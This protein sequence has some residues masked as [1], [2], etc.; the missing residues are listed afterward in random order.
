[1]PDIP[2]SIKAAAAALR[3]GQITSAQMTAAMLDRIE[4]LNPRVGAFIA[5]TGETAMAAAEQADA[6]LARGVDKG[7]LQGIPLAVKDIIATRDAPT[8]ANSHILDRSWG[9]HWDAPVVER[10]RMAG[11]VLMGKTVTSEFACGAPDP[12]KGFPMPK[13]PWNV[14]HSASGSSAGTGIAVAAG[15][16]LGGLGTDTGGSVRGPA[17]ANGH[18]GLKVS[19]GRVPKFGCVPLGYS[20]DSIGPMARS[21]WDCAALL[22]VIAGYDPR[23]PT[24]A[25]MTVPDYPKALTGEIKGLRVGVPRAYFFDAP[26]LDQEVKAAVLEGIDMLQ[27]AGAVVR[28]VTIPHADVAKNANNLIWAAEGFAY[29]RDDLRTRWEVYGRYTRTAIARGALF[30][31]PDYIQAQRVRS[32]FKKAVA[33]VMADLD[34]LVTPTSTT[35]AEKIDE[36][37]MDRRMLGASFTGMWNLIGLP[38]LAVPC[39][40]SSTGLPLSMQIVGKPF[41]EATVLR[42]GDAYQRVVDWHLRVP[43]IAVEVAA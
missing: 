30:N 22:K 3:D 35:P 32:Y 42:V 16:V 29:H 28:E 26:E 8:T 18:T 12:D 37:D 25:Q 39:G 24:A 6:D 43:P 4:H 40:F 11:A 33:A 34:V 27:R 7:P 9:A 20:L 17:S 15:M 10:L 19:F 31:G 14:E 36:M 13:N 5:V 1:M 21:A 41:D 2:L 23:D 38:A